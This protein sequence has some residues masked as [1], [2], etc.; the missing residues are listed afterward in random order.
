MAGEAREASAHVAADTWRGLRI[1][2]GRARAR[3][4]VA[5]VR[6]AFLPIVVASLAAGAAYL[7]AHSVVGHPYPFFA[8]TA[9]WV[10]LG[11]APDRQPRRVLELAIGVALGVGIG[12]AIVHVIGAG[13]WQVAVVLLVSALIGRFIDK[14]VLLTTQAGVQGVIIVLLPPTTGPTGRL[15]DALVGGGVALCVAMLSPRD[16]RRRLALLGHEAFNALAETLSLLAAGL[17]DG[18]ADQSRAAL[19]RGRAAEPALDEFGDSASNARDL[20]RVNARARRHVGVIDRAVEQAV[21]ADRVMRTVRVLARRTSALT[22]GDHETEPFARTMTE[23]AVGMRD[24]SSATG[25][26]RDA[27]R[28]RSELLEVAGSLDPRALAPGDWE[29]QALVLLARSAVVDALEAAG[30]AP[31]VARAALPEL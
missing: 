25:A 12:D 20:A 28:A 19:A 17:R 18:R 11:F 8:P 31:D 1:L 13:A 5:R 24:L 30:A 29:V 22:P 15:Y 16:P 6:T 26:G 2:V 4:G 3:Q 10:C 14:G 21:L 27:V 23:F 7:I 9:A